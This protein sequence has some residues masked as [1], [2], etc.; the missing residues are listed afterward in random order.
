MPNYTFDSSTVFTAPFT[1]RVVR[2][3]CWG[4]GGGGGGGRDLALYARGA[5]GGGAGAYALGHL[6]RVK[7][8]DRITIE[9]GSGGAGGGTAGDGTDGG[10][11]WVGT[12]I[13]VLAPGGRGGLS[14][15]PPTGEQGQGGQASEALGLKRAPGGRGGD[16]FYASA[17]GGGG[18]GG[19]AGSSFG[20]G[21]EGQDA[22]TG[23]GGSGAFPYDAAGV[24]GRGADE[25]QD[26]A[27][28][29]S[30]PGGG[31][32]GGSAYTFA[33]I[34]LWHYAVS[35][36]SASSHYLESEVILSPAPEHDPTDFLILDVLYTG[37]LPEEH[38]F[39]QVF[40]DIRDIVVFQ[41]GATFNRLLVV[42]ET[43]DP[44]PEPGNFRTRMR[45]NSTVT[46]GGVPIQSGLEIEFN[47]PAGAGGMATSQGVVQVRD[48]YLR[49]GFAWL[50]RVRVQA[51]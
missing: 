7:A 35:I 25:G 13:R 32:G 36:S 49:S 43:E 48:S 45:V 42:Q 10:A 9:V 40:D 34:P 24:G 22:T 17:G 3:K 8:G 33:H 47:L 44:E 14:R 11:S 50:Y 16:S 28:S 4:A 19:T 41:D 2:V 31:G 1:R 15:E 30:P 46:E 37:R 29:G 20:F 5:G 39:A 21:G 27:V 12:P 51:M 6:K 38:G 23:R 18:G 26:N